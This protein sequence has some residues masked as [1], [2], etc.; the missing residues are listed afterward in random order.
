MKLTDTLDMTLK[1]ILESCD[2]Q[3]QE[4]HTNNEGEIQN[5]EI[6]YTPKNE[7]KED[8]NPKL[9]RRGIYE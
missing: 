8:T 7:K 4:I 6:T 1:Q 3:K 9:T 5:I 2:I